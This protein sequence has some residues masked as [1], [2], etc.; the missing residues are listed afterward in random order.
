MDESSGAA[1]SSDERPSRHARPTDAASVH[2]A[3]S[4]A[5]L[6]VAVGTG[7][8][9]RPRLTWRAGLAY[10]AMIA[11]SI[12][13][14]ALIRARGMQLAGASG[15][16]ISID[17]A[18]P[19]T[20]AA[21]AH[22][23]V[24]VV[25]HLLLALLVIILAAR[26]LG[27]LFQYIHQPPVIGEIIGGILLGPS[28]LGRVA[29]SMQQ[30][31]LPAEVAPFVGAWSQVGAILF[32]F[33][34]GVQLDPSR[35]KGCGHAALVISH[36][37][38]VVPFLLG[39]MLAL[40]LYP[41]LSSSAV[42]FTTFSLFIGISMSVTAFPVLARIL[43]DRGVHA[44]RIGVIALACAAADD[45]TA[46]CLLAVV[47]GIVRAQL[48]GAVL[49]GAMAVAF[50][51]FAY[52]VARPLMR[53]LASIVEERGAVTQGML[54][55]VLFLLLASAAATHAIG[56]HTLIGAF[57]LG[58]I[59][60]HD[61]RLAREL[62]D[63]LEDLVVVLFL[64]AYFAFTG[65]RTEIG[66]IG[67]AEQW[68]LCAVI[69][70]VASMGKFGGVTLAAR[71][72]GLRWREASALGILMNTRGLMELVVLNIGYDLGLVSPTLFAMLVL[73]AIATTVATTP[74]FDRLT[75]EAAT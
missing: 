39:S 17:V 71:V 41:V 1:R 52:F 19:K 11:A 42:S 20:P 35:L 54:A 57:V 25:G 18:A 7:S 40:F 47:V 33:L 27:R 64:P 22:A 53:R 6:A 67:G 70:A 58:A 9:Q 62:V 36:A 50:V 28:L 49:T 4:G 14:Y 48:G 38:I 24:E 69:I 12:G 31:L 51:L 43:T 23:P 61:S 44:T 56:I 13:A 68:M 59:L 66:L 26:L 60:P 72:A 65:M 15:A 16:P 63:K 21:I 5:A 2:D 32:M 45:M 34:V 37:G 8:D 29:P 73:M 10:A 74:I 30:F 46:W 55:I 75:R 3:R